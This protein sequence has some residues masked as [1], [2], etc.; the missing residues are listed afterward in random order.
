[1]PPKS[2]AKGMR[3]P[4]ETTGTTLDAYS[5]PC[6]SEGESAAPLFR[7]QCLIFRCSV[8][9]YDGRTVKL[10]LHTD[11]P[12]QYL[13]RLDE[14]FLRGDIVWIGVQSNLYTTSKYESSTHASM[15]VKWI[16]LLGRGGQ[17]AWEAVIDPSDDERLSVKGDADA[18]PYHP[19]DVLPP[20]KDVPAHKLSR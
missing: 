4:V 3:K 7:I 14:G 18:V 8:P 6:E 20:L 16:T 1:M 10:P 12:Y 17:P 19:S 13:P 11:R 9:R 15:N 5:L 2:K